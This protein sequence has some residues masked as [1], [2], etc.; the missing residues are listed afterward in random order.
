MLEE[1]HG[2]V[3]AGWTVVSG[4]EMVGLGCGMLQIHVRVWSADEDVRHDRWQCQCQLQAAGA[5]VKRV[6]KQH[7][8]KQSSQKRN[9]R[10]VIYQG[11]RGGMTGS[12][13]RHA[14][15]HNGVWGR[16]SKMISKRAYVS[17]LAQAAM[18]NTRC[19]HVPG[20]ELIY[21]VTY[22]TSC[23]SS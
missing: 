23:P 14:R 21:S 15:P 20:H 13:V 8:R 9:V 22:L 1:T 6:V 19:C 16:K 7:N 3:R 11:S 10:S 18:C 4:R 12:H 17:V 2:V 5:L